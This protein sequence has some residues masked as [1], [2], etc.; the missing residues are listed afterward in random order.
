MRL[1]IGLPTRWP[2]RPAGALMLDTAQLA[3]DAGFAVL[4]VID[5]PN[6]D[7]WEPLTTL[8][9]V[10]GVTERIRLYTSAAASRIENARKKMPPRFRRILA[11]C[12][13]SL[14]LNP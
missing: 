5:K 9:G 13:T 6:Y 14:Q 4:G 12:W 3:D 2:T 7:S 1:G 10:A 11:T 8:A